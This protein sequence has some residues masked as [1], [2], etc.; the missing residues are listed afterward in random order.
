MKLK[1][2]L[3]K[4]NKKTNWIYNYYF[5]FIHAFGLFFGALLITEWT[6]PNIENYK[7]IFFLII[8]SIFITVSNKM[9]AY[10][11]FKSRMTIT[12]IIMGLIWIILTYLI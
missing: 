5:E 12:A 8:Y 9:S 3:I 4:L 6:F 10:K 1:K 2:M 11:Q 7:L